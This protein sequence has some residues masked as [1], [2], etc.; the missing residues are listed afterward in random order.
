MN[1]NYYQILGI[2]KDAS[3]IEIKK[4]YRKLAHQ[5]HPDK[6]GGDAKK[7]K[8]IN[9]AYQILSDKQKR[10]QYD[11]FG[12]VFEQGRPSGG[13]AND[14]GFQDFSDI[15]DGSFSGGGGANFG[16]EDIFG[17]IFGGASENRA[18]KQKRGKDIYVD[19]NIT[20]EE[21]AFGVNK[22]IDLYKG[23]IC[24][25]CKGSG[26]EHGF[27]IKQC[28]ICRGSGKIEERR[29]AGFFSFSQTRECDR[30]HG[31]GKIPAK[32]C[33][34]CGGDG[35]IKQNKKI[36]IDI[37]AGIEDTQIIRVLDEG[38]MGKFGAQA[39]DLYVAIHIIPHSKFNRRGNDLYYQQYISFTQAALGDKIKVPVLN[40]EVILQIPAGIES[41]T[42]LKLK[43]K[44]IR[45]MGRVGSLLVEIKI[46]TP[47][48]ISKKGKKLLEELEQEL[49]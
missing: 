20:L 47:K 18:Q 17:N 25:S 1:K 27:E 36:S 45:K 22:I 24:D 30:C 11:R 19:L 42:M 49:E 43:D 14:G 34:K 13:G 26:A 3:D 21:A 28:D 46:K 33:S 10:T 41:G 8:E 7:F 44:G 23:V 29:Q 2:S 12:T 40:G 16:W 9:E 4:A 15:F 32:N 37:P 5:Y 35:R 39:G 38:E 31:R 48:K 6:S